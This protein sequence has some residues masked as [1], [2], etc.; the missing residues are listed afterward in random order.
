MK[1]WNV[2]SGGPSREHLTQLDLIEEAP[3]VT[4]NRAIDVTDKGIGVD[5]AMF[6]DPPS[7]VVPNLK[8]EKYLTP[9]L[10]VWCPRS[11][12]LREGGVLQL[13]DFV[14]LWEPFLPASIGVRT[15]PTGTVDTED[16]TT[17]RHGFALLMALERIM[18]FRPERVRVLC[19]DM[20]GSW[21]PGLTEEE[22][23]MHQSEL[24]Q[25]KRQLSSAQKQLNA[26]GGKNK[27]YEVMRDNLQVMLNELLAKGNPG[28][29]KRWAHERRHLK[30]L[31]ARAKLVGCEFEW[32]SPKAITA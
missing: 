8:L 27:T 20:M 15:T 13:L 19:A 18:L 9:P 11:N 5:F 22:C 23:E 10:Q 29:F 24:E 26:S 31:E 25:Y 21:A 3:V 28:K 4:I 2:I 1:K 16:P 14:T 17:R 32:R 6:A 12:L 7:H 30:E